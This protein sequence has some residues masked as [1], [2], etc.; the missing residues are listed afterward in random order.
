M[1]ESE[2]PLAYANKHFLDQVSTKAFYK[3]APALA[4]PS[5]TGPP[6]R[7]ELHATL[8][9]MDLHLIDPVG[10]SFGVKF[11]LYLLWQV[12][13]HA[14]GLAHLADKALSAG[15]FYSLERDEYDAFAEA[16]AIPD[17]LVSNQLFSESAEFPDMRV[18][19]GSPG[20]TAVMWN[21]SY[22]IT[23]RER[24]ELQ[25]F[26][27][28]MQEL[29]VELRLN[30]PKTWD[31]FDLCVSMV[32]FHKQAILLPEWRMYA[33]I[34]RKGSPKEKVSSVSMLVERLPGYYVQ[35]VVVTMLGLSIVALAAFAMEVS[36]VGDRVNTCLTLNLTNVAFK[37]TLASTLPKVPYNT[38]IDYFMLS[39]AATL[40]LM[41]FLCIIPSFFEGDGAVLAN[42]LLTVLSA[43][44]VLSNALAWV[45]FARCRTRHEKRTQVVSVDS[46]AN[47][48]AFQYSTP[49][50]LPE[51]SPRS[52]R[53]PGQPGAGQ[54]GGSKDEALTGTG[55]G[56][57]RAELQPAASGPRSLVPRPLTL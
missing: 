11:R 14:V 42:R 9:V 54:K 19:W 47:W 28:D 8:G 20:A 32:Q 12:D 43:G 39:S 55:S 15:H 4:G 27:F 33:P 17:I 45:I 6:G 18:Y 50:F 56:S 53:S 21:R 35:N 51:L 3:G 29:T 36:A 40:A 38:I 22:N 2:T 26:P 49:H 41:T 46:K 44:L 10:E 24:F 34:V 57:L 48:Y 37:F 23:C 1:L 7:I 31:L 52:P 25:D 30:D 16:S 5:A 13:L